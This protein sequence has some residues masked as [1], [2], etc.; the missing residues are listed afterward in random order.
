MTEVGCDVMWCFLL[1]PGSVILDRRAGKQFIIKLLSEDNRIRGM[2]ITFLH[3]CSNEADHSAV[4]VGKII[5]THSNV[6]YRCEWNTGLL[7][8]YHDREKLGA[9]GNKN[10]ETRSN[11]F[12]LMLYKSKSLSKFDFLFLLDLQANCWIQNIICCFWCT[13]CL[14]YS[15]SIKQ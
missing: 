15:P 13:A 2:T 5:P 12:Y 4:G 6:K 8:G 14:H 3:C 1:S 10:E 11:E 7:M 9:L